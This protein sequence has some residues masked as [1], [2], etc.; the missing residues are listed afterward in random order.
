MAE[1]VIFDGSIP[2][3]LTG[4]PPASRPAPP[5]P[6]PPV[7]SPPDPVELPPVAPPAPVPSPALV[8]DA[9]VGVP[10]PAALAVDVVPVVAALDVVA[11]VRV[12][13]L[14]ASLEQPKN[15][16][17]SKSH[18]AARLAASRMNWFAAMW[19]SVARKRY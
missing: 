10:E 7:P 12:S 6:L 1:S 16:I 19:A 11:A 8:L 3:S 9:V 5:V 17:A 15:G 2:A 4:P 14:L 13:L 18:A